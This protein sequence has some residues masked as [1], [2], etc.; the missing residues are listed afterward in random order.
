MK[1]S[2]LVLISITCIVLLASCLKTNSETCHYHI[3]VH[4]ETSKSVYVDFAIGSDNKLDENRYGVLLRGHDWFKVSPGDTNFKG[5]SRRSC[6]E[7]SF[8]Y[9]KVS[10]ATIYLYDSDVLEH[11]DIATLVKDQYY[12]RKFDVTLQELQDMGWELKIKK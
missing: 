3:L 2:H 1:R 5:L 10:T 9:S 12:A 4:N 8:K 11:T 6:I 7:S